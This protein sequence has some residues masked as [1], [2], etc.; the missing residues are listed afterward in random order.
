MIN[1]IISVLFRITHLYPTLTSYILPI[2]M[3]IQTHPISLTLI[4]KIFKPKS[5]ALTFIP[6][7]TIILRTFV[8]LPSTGVVPMTFKY[9]TEDQRATNISC[10][11]PC[12]SAT[13]DSNSCLC[14][15]ISLSLDTRC[16]FH[17]F[18]PLYV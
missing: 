17:F 6:L 2:W 7:K 9:L 14:T 18:S 11:Y 8:F 16:N 10:L 12:N 1:G 4:F 13:L 3:Y 15:C 5:T